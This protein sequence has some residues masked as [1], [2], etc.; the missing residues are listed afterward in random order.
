MLVGDHAGRGADEKVDL[1]SVQSTSE[2]VAVLLARVNQRS[3]SSEPFRQL[4]R[5]QVRQRL[6]DERIE[7]AAID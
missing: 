5:R 1:R 3:R 4:L 2:L 7:V 6:L